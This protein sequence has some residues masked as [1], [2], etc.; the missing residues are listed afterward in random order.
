M[1]S[2]NSVNTSLLAP[3]LTEDDFIKELVAQF[4]RHDGYVDTAKAFSQDVQSASK[5]LNKG[6]EAPLGRFSIQEDLDATNRQRNKTC[7]VTV[8]ILC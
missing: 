6:M 2:I 4:L 7:P 5:A 3:P 1:S 8:Y